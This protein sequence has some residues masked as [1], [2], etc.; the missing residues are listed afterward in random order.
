M[1]PAAADGDGESG[2]ALLGNL[3]WVDATAGCGD[4]HATCLGQANRGVKP[5]LAV[6][7]DEGDPLEATRLFVGG[8]GED[9]V[10]AQARD[11]ILRWIE[12]G[13]ASALAEESNHADLHR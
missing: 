6:L 3:Q 7:Q 9:D 8:G 13:G 10:A 12:T 4:R 2:E 11:H 5:V 1:T